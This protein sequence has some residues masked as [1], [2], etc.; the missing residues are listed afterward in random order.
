MSTISDLWKKEDWWTIWFGL[1]L[2]GFALLM[3]NLNPQSPV[4]KKI[5]PA[6]V[7]EPDLAKQAIGKSSIL[8]IPNKTPKVGK[9]IDN[10]L[11]AFKGGLPIKLIMLMIGLGV[12]TGIGVAVMGGS[13]WRY[14]LAFFVV[15]I[16]STLSY[17]VANQQQIK[18]YGIS[19]AFWAL[20][21]GLLISNTVGTPKWLME[22]VKTEMYIK[23][24]LVLL[25]AEILFSKILLLGAPGLFVAWLVTPTVIIFMYSFGTRFL[26]VKKTLSVII[27]AA[28]S[29]CGVSAAIATAAACKAKKDEL[30]LAVG[31]TL[32]FTVIMMIVM[33]AFISVVDMPIRIGA[34]W[35]GGTIDSTGAVVAAGAVLG[36][37][38]EK[39]AA[40]VKMIQNVLIGVVA[41]LVAVYWVTR[42]ADDPKAPRPKAMEIWY[43]FPKFI[44]GFVGASI[45]FSFILSP[46]YTTSVVEGGV[47]DPFTHPFRSWFFC[48]AFLS[49]GLESN[50][51]ELAEQMQGGKPLILYVVGQSFNLILTLLA[52]WLAFGGILFNI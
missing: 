38:A 27:A 20:A 52:A 29:V 39:I 14:L 25:G 8:G 31:M 44:L 17:W 43:R 33:P 13:F 18:H 19:Y 12:L 1:I 46:I 41:F 15:F 36:D 50:F 51:R 45:I 34:A 42:V 4:Y 7:Q 5:H 6:E 21:I 30:T 26:K 28:T 40:V 32:I 22:G 9:W 24:G 47:I 2:I 10:P 48:M 3:A 35:M 37:E 11:E 49:I 23:T 16:L